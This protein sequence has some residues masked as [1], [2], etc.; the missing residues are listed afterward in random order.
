V[1]TLHI[2]IFTIVA[3]A[4]GFTPRESWR[5]WLIF[6]ASIVAVFWLQPTSPIRQLDFWLPVATISITVLAWVIVQQRGFMIRALLQSLGV[7][8]LI[9]VALALMRYIDEPIC[10]LTAS[11]PPQILP[12]LIVVGAV[13]ALQAGASRVAPGVRTVQLAL[14]IILLTLLLVLKTEALATY[15]SAGLRTLTDQPVAFA[16]AIDIGWIGISYVAFRL[17]HVLLDR[18]N[19]VLP[20]DIAL[21]EFLSYVLFFP[22]LVAGPL[23]QIKPFAAE[24]RAR[25]AMNAPAV[26][27]AGLRIVTGMFKKFVIADALALIALDPAAAL[28][29]HSTLWTWIALYAYAFRIY[30]DFAGYSDIAIGLGRLAGFSIPENFD[31]P[32]LKSNLTL[33]WNSWHMTL[34]NWFRAYYF[35][36]ISR[37]LRQ[38]ARNAS[39]A[40]II[41]F[42]Q[43]TTMFLIGLW[44]GVSWNFAI[45]GLWHGIGLFVHNR[46]ANA[47]RVQARKLESQPRLARLVN[48]LSVLLTFH[49][50]ALG[51]VWFAL[52][53][54][55]TAWRVFLRLFGLA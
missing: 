9:I 49:Y 25:L 52:D 36:P 16:K 30:F 1:Q 20:E 2:G 33:F 42:S 45:W 7:I 29:T 53:D 31:R 23:D 51:W 35:N 55:G 39:P 43:I 40:L 44:H 8:A 5:R 18:R 11:R 14:L 48:V 17:M 32:Y 12:V 22:T 41:A 19:G 27:D 15:A 6:A 10:C 4:A 38:R 21:P 24:F 50:V 3:L 54:F 28:N 37:D 26:F 13:V 34:S 46:Y 47:T